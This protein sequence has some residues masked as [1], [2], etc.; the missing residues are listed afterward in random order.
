[1]LPARKRKRIIDDKEGTSPGTDTGG[2]QTP[3]EDPEEEIAEHSAP[4]EGPNLKEEAKSPDTK[5]MDTSCALL[6]PSKVCFYTFLF[7]FINL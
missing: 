7:L 3:G 1:M 2:R 6:S 5:P 4:E